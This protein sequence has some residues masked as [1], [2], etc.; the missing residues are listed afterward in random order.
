MEKFP[1]STA[2]PTL[3]WYTATVRVLASP[4]RYLTTSLLWENSP[5]KR[6]PCTEPPCRDSGPHTEEKTFPSTLR[7]DILF[8]SFFFSSCVVCNW[9]FHFHDRISGSSCVVDFHRSHGSKLHSSRS[10]IRCLLGPSQSAM[11]QRRGQLHDRPGAHSLFRSRSEQRVDR[12][13]RRWTACRDR[14]QRH[15]RQRFFRFRHSHR[16]HSTNFLHAS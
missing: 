7:Y 2:F 12:K 15:V 13:S 3:R 9:K 4:G 14:Q 1:I 10:S 11:H 16:A 8:S 5:K 6:T